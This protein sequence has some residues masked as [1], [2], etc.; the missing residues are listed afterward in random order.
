MKS[1]VIELRDLTG[2][3]FAVWNFKKQSITI[4]K[5]KKDVEFILYDNGTYNIQE[6]SIIN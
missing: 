1:D 5:N 3:L 6:T 4:R 2:K